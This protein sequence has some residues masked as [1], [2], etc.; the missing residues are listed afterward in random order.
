M[1]N[2]VRPESVETAE[3]FIYLGKS[4]GIFFFIHVIWVARDEEMVIRMCADVYNSL[5][6]ETMV[7]TGDGLVVYNHFLADPPRL[8][9][10]YVT[11]ATFPQITFPRGALA[12]MLERLFSAKRPA[13]QNVLVITARLADKTVQRYDLYELPGDQIS[14]SANLGACPPTAILAPLKKAVSAKPIPYLEDHA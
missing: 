6:S 4:S 11:H 7:Q 12:A 14:L 13:A 5:I 8:L 3:N 10:V 1:S 2:R 9:P